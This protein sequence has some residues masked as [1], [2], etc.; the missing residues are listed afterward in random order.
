M[1]RSM[2]NALRLVEIH[3]KTGMREVAEPG[4]INEQKIF[5]GV[6]LSVSL[7]ALFEDNPRR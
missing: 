7:A 1:A 3:D 5:A 4:T 6:E 2:L